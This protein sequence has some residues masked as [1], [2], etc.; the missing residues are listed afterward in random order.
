M[1]EFL[2]YIERSL[3]L[4]GF[5]FHGKFDGNPE[6]SKALK[7]IRYSNFGIMVISFIQTLA[8]CIKSDWNDKH[9]V[10]TILHA[11]FFYI[12]F[13]R[14]YVLMKNLTKIRNMIFQINQVYKIDL[15]G[16]FHLEGAK[17]MELM[18]KIGF[19]IVTLLSFLPILLFISGLIK[20]AIF[21]SKSEKPT[22]LFNYGLYFPFDVYDHL[23]W[24]HIYICY[25]DW[26]SIFS[27][28]IF[29][30]L[31]VLCSISFV[32]ICFEKLADD[33]QEVIERCKSET[34]DETRK[35]LKRCVDIHNQL[36]EFCNE[37]NSIFRILI[38]QFSILGPVIVAFLGY[39]AVV[40]NSLFF[41]C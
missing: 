32:A 14:I 26:L 41:K 39:R 3:F 31:L 35:K 4:I 20:I 21:W 19:R 11:I 37:I 7:I 2:N 30:Q 29:D 8:Y 16:D 9:I 10:D 1:K 33:F 22:N 12:A 40:S 6:R 15:N 27:S 28:I 34:L 25:V 36:I 24:T 23:P 18:A 5:D 38:L 13:S 17:F